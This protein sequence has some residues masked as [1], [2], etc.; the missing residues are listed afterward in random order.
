MREEGVEKS[1]SIISSNH[2]PFSVPQALS[3]SFSVYLV[4]WTQLFLTY[5][6]SSTSFGKNETK[7]PHHGSFQWHLF[8]NM[9]WPKAR[10]HQ[11]V[12]SADLPTPLIV[13]EMNMKKKN[14][15]WLVTST[16]RVNPV[17]HWGRVGGVSDVSLVIKLQEGR[18]QSSYVNRE[19]KY[20]QG[21]HPHPT[22][23]LATF[24]PNAIWRSPFTKHSQYKTPH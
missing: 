19:G 10:L 1:G 4:N 9:S 13:L 18:S 17:M 23:V 16:G 15:I 11:F 21:G 6:L 8:A 7:K 3:F 2:F 14:V 22:Q 20:L 24:F 5:L 12:L